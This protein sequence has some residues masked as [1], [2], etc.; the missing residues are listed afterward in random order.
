MRYSLAAMSIHTC[1]DKVEVKCQVV[2]CLFTYAHSPRACTG[3]WREQ[4]V[5]FAVLMIS[6]QLMDS[7]PI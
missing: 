2:T 6:S 5:S 1:Q 4:Q 3:S 7:E